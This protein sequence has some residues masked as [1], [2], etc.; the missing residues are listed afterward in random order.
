MLMIDIDSLEKKT[1]GVSIV[2][3]AAQ[4]ILNKQHKKKRKRKKRSTSCLS[5]PSGIL[6]HIISFLVVKSLIIL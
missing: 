4:H 2:Q 1:K 3:Q 5:I 6:F